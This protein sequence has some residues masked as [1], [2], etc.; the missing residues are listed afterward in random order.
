MARSTLV[1]L[2]FVALS[3]VCSGQEPDVVFELVPRSVTPDSV[4]VAV[5]FSFPGSY[6][7]VAGWS[8]SVGH[9]PAL[10][11]IDSWEWGA[12]AAVSDSGGPPGIDP[13]HIYPHG[14]TQGVVLGGHL[15]GEYL[16]P[17]ENLEMLII[18]YTVI[19][20]DSDFEFSFDPIGT[21][22]VS[23]VLVSAGQ[24]VTPTTI[25]LTLDPSSVDFARGDCNG[26][27]QNDLSDS[28]FL[29]QYLFLGGSAP[30]CAAACDAND[31]GRLD[32]ADSI[33]N[34]SHLFVGG[35]PPSPPFGAC[36]QDPTPDELDCLG[37]AC[38]D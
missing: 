32:I 30:S 24:S 8:L 25:E 34:L 31:D 38:T 37:P 27:G 29:E 11:Q 15:G 14:M 10:L 36:G 33:T 18:H 21:P 6:P 2:F 3:C 35:P 22:P 16:E 26:D 13:T 7:L 28:I 19:A 17:G 9:D 20:S 4:T 12:V 1:L 5:E 23:T